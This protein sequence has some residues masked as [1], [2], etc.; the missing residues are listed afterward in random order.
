M[1]ERREEHTAAVVDSMP[2][3]SCTLSTEFVLQQPITLHVPV[4]GPQS[5]TSTAVTVSWAL[6]IEFVVDHSASAA[7]F[8]DASAGG[9]A[10]ADAEKNGV[11]HGVRFAI[12][13]T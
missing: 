6:V 13:E 1:L 9:G 3:D 8:V 11:C 5:F 4:Q 7:P 12:V 10:G 2:V